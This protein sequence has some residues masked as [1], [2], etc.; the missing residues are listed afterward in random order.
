MS[1]AMH[2]FSRLELVVG[3]EGLR[4]LMGARILIFGLGG[5]GSYVVEG[6]ARA[7]I[8]SFVLVDNDTISITNRNRQL[9]ALASTTGRRK[10]EVVAEHIMDIN[11]RAQVEARE[12]FYLPERGE[13]FFAELGEVSYA[14]DAID[15]ITAK[16]DLACRCE[17]LGIPIISS[18]G[19]GNK[20]D[21]TRFEVADIYKTSVDPLARVMRKKLKEKGVKGLK[22][23]YSREE[24]LPVSQPGENPDGTPRRAVPGSVSFVPS[25]AG[26]IIAGEVVK[27]I[28]ASS[29]KKDLGNN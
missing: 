7:G 23:V 3:K 6:L 21:P 24:P 9:P 14:V 26:L 16:I 20:L 29:L 15:T 18:M 12:F 8:G 27:D 22:V 1:E 2:E 4:K 10:A 11:P 25:V 19:T 13:K 28:L 5:V 17:K